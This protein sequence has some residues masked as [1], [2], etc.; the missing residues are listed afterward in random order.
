MKRY[1]HA[2][3][4]Y[5]LFLFCFSF[6][7]NYYSISSINEPITFY[8]R[9]SIDGLGTFKLQFLLEDS[10]DDLVKELEYRNKG[11]KSLGHT[12]GADIIFQKTKWINFGGGFEIQFERQLSDSP[13]SFGFNSFYG[14]IQVNTSSGLIYF[15]RYGN[16]YFHGDGDFTSD[17]FGGLVGSAYV[18]VGILTRFI[19]NIFV[20]ISRSYMHSDINY[21][22]GNDL[23]W[24]VYE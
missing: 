1:F 13:S 19:D 14:I 11:P 12:I 7:K 16:T 20:E 10:D 23:M 17:G 24:C 22:A 5:F 8:P 6:S 2:K 4:I 3:L 9:F 18:S 21:F 15:A